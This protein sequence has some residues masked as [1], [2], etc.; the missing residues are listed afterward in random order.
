LHTREPYKQ[1]FLNDD[2]S[3]A[4]YTFGILNITVSKM[5]TISNEHQVFL[6]ETLCSR[7]LLLYYSK[8][9]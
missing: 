2:S 9:S 5:P 1:G 8:N 4:N 3:N 6:P 7:G